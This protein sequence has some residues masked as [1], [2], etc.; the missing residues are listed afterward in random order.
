[1]T[2]K[3]PIR[4]YIP[5]CRAVKHTWQRRHHRRTRRIIHEV[6]QPTPGGRRAGEIVGELRSALEAARAGDS[7]VSLQRPFGYGLVQIEPVRVFREIDRFGRLHVV[8]VVS[9]DQIDGFFAVIIDAAETSFIF[10]DQKP[11]ELDEDGNI[12][13]GRFA[14]KGNIIRL[15][16][17]TQTDADSLLVADTSAS[18]QFI[19]SNCAYIYSRWTFEQGLFNGDPTL[20]CIVR[21]RKTVD[22]R[23]VTDLPETV[24]VTATGL[25]GWVSRVDGGTIPVTEGSNRLVVVAVHVEGTDSSP[26]AVTIGNEPMI[27]QEAGDTGSGFGSFAAIFTMDEAGLLQRDNDQIAVTVSGS[28]NSDNIQIASVVYENIDQSTPVFHTDSSAD[29]TSSTAA[30]P[31]M[32]TDQRGI[33]VALFGGSGSVGVG[34][35]DVSWD[36][37]TPRI[38][39][40][41]DSSTM[42]VS[43]SATDGN[44]VSPTPVPAATILRSV[45]VSIALTPSAD[46]LAGPFNSF[47]ALPKRFSSSPVIQAYDFL[48]RPHD[49]GG[50]QVPFE[51][52]DHDSFADYADFADEAV[53]TQQSTATAI[54]TTTSNLV[55]FNRLLEFQQAITPFQYGDIVRVSGANGADL[56]AGL[57]GS[58]DYHVIP[59]RHAIGE[60][61]LPAIMLAET[62]EQAW[63][64][65]FVSI[66]TRFTD[67]EVSKRNDVRFSS[68]F[69]Y[70]AGERVLDDLLLACGASLY[71]NNGKIAIT[72]QQFPDSSKI[73]LVN[74]DDVLSEVALAP[75][76]GADEVATSIVGSHCS[77]KNLF[78]KRDYPE[79]S[80]GGV[81]EALD[82]K[83][84]AKR[85]NLDYVSKPSVGQRLALVELRKRRQPKTVAFTGSLSLFRL[86]PGQVFS[87]DFEQLALDENTTFQVQDQTIFVNFSNDVPFIGVEVIGRQLESTTYNLA[88]DDEDFVEDVNI[89]GL[90]SPF[91][92]AQPIGLTATESLFEAREGGGL[93]ARVTLSWIAPNDQFVENYVVSYKTTSAEDFIFLAPTVDLKVQ[94]D[95]IV[96]DN[97]IFRVRSVNSIGRRSDP[98][99]ITQQIQGL[100]APPDDPVNFIGNVVGDASVFLSWDLSQDL[101]VRQ[102]GFVEIRHDPDIA[103]GK[104][105]GSIIIRTTDGGQSGDFSPFKTGTYYIRFQDSTGNYSG[106]SSWSTQDR[107]PVGEADPLPGEALVNGFTIEEGPAFGS[108]VGGNT[109]VKNG[110][111]IEL[112]FED[113]W[114]DEADVDAITDVDAVGGGGVVPEGVYQFTA[115]TGEIELTESTRLLVETVLIMQLTDTSDNLDL[116]QDIDAVDDIDDVGAS[117]VLAGLG[118]AWIETRVSQDTIAD[119]TFGPWERV[120]TAI[121]SHRSYQ[122]RVQ[123]RSFADTVNV[124]ITKAS[125][126]MR[127]IPI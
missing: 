80:G 77:L 18:N 44:D 25:D 50:A 94:I 126:R 92:I 62:L 2:K 31:L 17:G 96:P 15:Y 52:V 65:D 125:V 48:L 22:P 101:D 49:R 123:A 34:D 46:E 35:I 51:L 3:R 59:V 107:R 81:F 12:I 73:S 29:D 55:G 5:S 118:T 87:M 7:D 14:D 102:G 110:S 114:D 60:T 30:A 8:D 100:K 32:L 84:T 43:A 36:N 90:D 68:N 79:A 61:T 75:A 33:I 86:K 37:I 85:F 88:L 21:A 89:P 122:F 120:D 103:G 93:K 109:M 24:P 58:I 116:V 45:I 99:E 38:E 54:L 9:G 27:L 28:I 26:T 113:T 105:N 112:P 56:P 11:D 19:G 106:F 111:L 67:I 41:G 6:A 1:M 64:G 47:E 69:A 115:G 71:L 127:A 23:Q 72:G 91:A 39:I 119:D 63:S 104:E 40:D 42:S 70:S 83:R 78:L 13:L 57:S 66:G 76:L 53:T 10:P 124:Q 97:Y 95:D 16:D 20:R 121:F 117:A 4:R 74:Q 82:G 108:L 98:T